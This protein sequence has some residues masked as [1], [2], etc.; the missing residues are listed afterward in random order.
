[1]MSEECRLAG[2]ARGLRRAGLAGF[3]ARFVLLA[4]AQ[5]L[6]AQSPEWKQSEGYR[7]AAVKVPTTGRAGFTEVRAQTGIEFTNTLNWASAAKNHNLMQSAGVAA[8]DFD[9]DGLCDLYFC[10]VEGRNSLY[11]NLGNWRFADVTDQAGVA[12]PGMYS[13]GAVF[14]DVDGDGR[15]DLLVSGNNG[16]NFYFHNQGTGRFTNLTAAAGLLSRPLGATSMA[17]ADLNGDGA[18]DLFVANYGEN[19][20]LR[21]G[22]EFSVRM[23]NGKPVVSGRA[24]RRLKIIDGNLVEYGEPPSIY[25]NDGRGRFTPLSWTDGTFLDEDGKPFREAPMDLALSVMMR[26]INGDGIPDIYVC[27]DFQQPDRIWINDGRAKFR[28]LPWTAMRHQSRFSM[29]VDFADVDRDGHDDFIVVDM[30]SRL[31]ALRM[32]QSTDSNMMAGVVGLLDDRPQ[33]RR[34]TLFHNRGDGTYAET[35]NFAGVDASDWTWTP[36]FLDVDLDGYEDLLVSNGHAFD[37]QDLDTAAQTPPNRRPGGELAHLTSYPRLHTPN[38][39]FRN[40]RDGTFEETGPRWSFNS[41]Q[42]CHGVICADLDNDGDLDVVVSSLNAPPLIYRNDSDAPRIAVRLKGRGANTRGINA[43]ITV[44]GGAVPVQAQEMIC[45]GRYL[46]ADEP[47]RAFAAG[48]PTNRLTIEVNW[49][50]GTR[51]V[52]RDLPANAI[53]EIDEAGAGPAELPKPKAPAAPLFK[54]VSSLLNHRHHEEPFDDFARQPLL[55]RKLSQL[56][57]GVAWLDLD[58]DG[59]DELVV[60]SGRG[61]ALDMFNSHGKDAFTKSSLTNIATDDLLG[62]AAWHNEGKPALLVARAGYETSDSSMVLS[63]QAAGAAF[64]V[65]INTGISHGSIS[66]LAVADMD[67]DGTL[68][69]F[70]GNRVVA[71]R[72]PE[73]WSSLVNTQLLHDAGM[74]SGAVWSDLDGDGFPELIL[75]CEWGPLKIFRNARGKLSPWNPPVQLETQNAKPEILSQLTGWWTSVTTGDFDGDGRMDIVAGNWGLN[76]SHQASFTSPQRLYY[77]DLNG[78]GL[79]SLIEAEL[80]G[81]LNKV[82]PR[83]NLVMLAP[84]LPFLRARYPTHASFRAA[85]VAEILGDRFRAAQEL[86]AT[87]LATTLLLNRG[88]H[89]ESVPLPPEAQWAPVFGMSVADMDGDGDED[90][91][92]AQNFFA[93]RKD[94]PRLDAGRGLWLNNDGG[95]NFR[96]MGATESGVVA[97]GEQRGCAVGDFN[98]DGRVDLLLA[99]NGGETRLFENQTARPGL[100]VRLQGPPGNPAGLGAVIRLKHADGFG[101]AREIHGGGGYLSQDSVV[102]V[103]GLRAKPTHVLVR[104][105]GG[106]TTEGPV[107]DGARE[108]EF[109]FSP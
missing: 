64:E 6:C 95:G 40:R 68:D 11:R 66:C 103:L 102:P 49:R 98:E 36:V 39:A 56:G 79:M 96:A 60:G 62:L 7:S 92:L 43:R 90:L 88:D 32:T 45:G 97:W 94:V 31:H 14:A 44:R 19:T 67:G 77:G 78:D 5:S 15:L 53:Y 4:A 74:V 80:D 16:P 34:N 58:G 21:S 41:T 57:P 30:L 10:S 93:T 23:V 75:A 37:T 38:Y 54:D 82:V 8:G 47:V 83:E 86:A 81:A 71:G 55:P 108:V 61:G 65:N 89:F 3:T 20:V 107:A 63:V 72:Y 76:S 69:R 84:A 2:A 42:A 109:R 106:K 17:L 29:G 59:H 73:V 104:W 105:P 28:A 33:I 12:C 99:Q 51:S 9:G 52:I 27:N 50:S 46:S 13:T 35:A 70:I 48:S 85:G 25:L 87:T 26:D 100:R 18:L 101:P 91:F 24:G 22:G 1:M